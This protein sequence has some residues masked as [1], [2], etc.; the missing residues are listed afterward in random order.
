MQTCTCKHGTWADGAVKPGK[1]LQVNL[2]SVDETHVFKHAEDALQTHNTSRFKVPLFSFA[3]LSLLPRPR[4]LTMGV[5]SSGRERG[6]YVNSAKHG[7]VSLTGSIPVTNSL[8]TSSSETC[9]GH[10]LSHGR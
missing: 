5:V 1:S 6:V 9:N 3:L 10:T 7:W 4:F 8:D 2:V